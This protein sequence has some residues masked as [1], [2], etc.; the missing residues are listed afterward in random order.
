MSAHSLSLPA[1]IFRVQPV[2][3]SIQIAS[4]QL[5]ACVYLCSVYAYGKL[6]LG[7]GRWTYRI[8]IARSPS[9]QLLLIRT[10]NPSR[11]IPIVHRRRSFSSYGDAVWVL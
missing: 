3:Q 7:A 8:D 6:K 11:C 5:R 4:G 1:L 2:R 10:T 9:G